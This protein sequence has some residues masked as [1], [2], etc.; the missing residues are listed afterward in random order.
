[1]EKVIMASYSYEKSIYGK[2][3]MARNWAFISKHLLFEDSS[4]LFEDSLKSD[5]FIW[6]VY[7][8]SILFGSERR[9]QMLKDEGRVI[10][11]F[12]YIDRK[13][14]S[15]SGAFGLSWEGEGGMSTTLKM[16]CQIFT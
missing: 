2:H 8:R 15:E 10:E 3:V 5:F 12:K 11:R 1:M 14:F 4:I 16:S 13:S 7:F 9:Y 6:H